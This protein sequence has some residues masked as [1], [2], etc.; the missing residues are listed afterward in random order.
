[1]LE[2]V[3]LEVVVEGIRIVSDAES[4]G[5]R[6]PDIGGCDNEAV[7]AKCNANKYRLALDDLN[8]QLS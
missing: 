7:D 5:K 3:S 1:M 2:V 4:C 6:I 8:E